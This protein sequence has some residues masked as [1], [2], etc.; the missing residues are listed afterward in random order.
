MLFGDDPAVLNGGLDDR[1]F[2]IEAQEFL[3]GNRL[4]V[5][6][7]LHLVAEKKQPMKTQW[8]TFLGYEACGD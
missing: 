6:A 7:F 1:E 5:L 8:S 2:I 3:D 4:R